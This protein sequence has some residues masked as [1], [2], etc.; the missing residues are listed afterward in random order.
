MSWSTTNF[1]NSESDDTLE[2][3]D[4]DADDQRIS[5]QTRPLKHRRRPKRKFTHFLLDDAKGFDCGGVGRKRKVDCMH[6]SE[7]IDSGGDTMVPE[8]IVDSCLPKNKEAKM[9]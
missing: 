7:I 2:T 4:N 6:T 8:S 5:T 9:K 1:A 3:V